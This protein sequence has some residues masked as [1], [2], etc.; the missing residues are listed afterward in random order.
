MELFLKIVF[1]KQKTENLFGGIILKN[2]FYISN[3]VWFRIYLFNE[4]F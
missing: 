1:K 2:N 3:I 4:E